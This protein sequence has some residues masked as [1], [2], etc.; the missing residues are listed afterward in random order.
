MYLDFTVW[1]SPGDGDGWCGRGRAPPFLATG[2]DQHLA[3]GCRASVAPSLDVEASVDVLNK[4]V[5]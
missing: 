1:L 3:L 5:S 2:L 4:S